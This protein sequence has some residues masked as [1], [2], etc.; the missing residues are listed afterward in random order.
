M[1]NVRMKKSFLNVYRGGDAERNKFVDD[2][3]KD[4]Q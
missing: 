2:T 1:Y 3:T 4:E